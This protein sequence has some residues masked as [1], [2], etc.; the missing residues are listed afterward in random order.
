MTFKI[1]EKRKSVLEANGHCLV[2]GGP[3]SGKT[4]LAL[5][6]ASQ[7]I[8]NGLKP[9]QGVLFLSFSRAAVARIVDAT[10]GTIPAAHYSALS[11]QTF[12]SFFWQILQ[13][14]GYLLNAPRPLSIILA[15]DEKAMRDGI[16][17]ESPA[18][19]QWEAKRKQ[20]F[21]VEGRLCF[22][23]FA[24][25][26]ALL[27]SRAK[28][29]RDRI[30]SRY[31][32]ILVDEAQDTG[33]EQWECIKLLAEKAQVICLADPDQMIYDF[34]PG[35][36]PARID[37][38]REVLKPHEVD[39][40]NENNRSPATE[41]LAF[42]R[43]ILKSKVRGS[44]YRGVSRYRFQSSVEN[45]DK[46]IRSSIGILAK[47]IKD[48][49]G[50]PAKSVALIAS[51]GSGV[52]VISSALQQEKPIQ[53]QVLFDEAVALLA[54]TASAFLLEPKTSSKH[55]QDIAT[56]LE[57]TGA[58]FRAKGT[59]TASAQW[60]QCSKYAARC[61]IGDVPSFKI[62]SAASSLIESSRSRK[63]TGDPRRDWL[64]VKQDL[65]QLGG[66]SFTEIASS[67]DYIVAFARG[68]RIAEAL[69]TIWMEHG[70]YPGAREAL[71]AA[72]AQEQ[73]LSAGE[74]LYGIH[75]M[76]THK[77]KGKQFDGVVLYRQEHHSPFVWR[78]ESSP[79][80]SSRRLLHMAITRARFHVVL[81]DDVYSACPITD[82][83]PL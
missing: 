68:K 60:V 10:K 47:Q 53:H 52:A 82:P 30:T 13:G 36:G 34:L 12:H 35:V 31:P 46:A 49:T 61:R 42:A 6:K 41:I 2:T 38:I 9:G 25:L 5:V 57:L 44:A 21:H 55:A 11:I 75:V 4:T 33:D 54:I 51:Y 40:G 7:R 67:L 58:A 28:S 26:T 23:L 18:W 32:L 70:A 69:S 59:K 8:G 27:L 63:F 45:R 29:I 71:H 64:Q 77:C 17:R 79:Y 65:R 1:C 72:L 76:N 22:D 74:E 43:D 15:H 37:Q 14:Y 78:N 80:E 19:A 62:V 73:L 16:E 24:P 39:L 50:I 3:G 83:H 56:L 48:E 20:L 66:N 81:L